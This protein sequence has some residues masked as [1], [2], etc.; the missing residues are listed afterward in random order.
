[1][2]C[3]KLYLG[4]G[5]LELFVAAATMQH[6]VPSPAQDAEQSQEAKVPIRKFLV[7]LAVWRNPRLGTFLG[8]KDEARPSCNILQWTNKHSIASGR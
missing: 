3:V 4:P 2:V 1:M 7:A 8:S 5:I 6:P